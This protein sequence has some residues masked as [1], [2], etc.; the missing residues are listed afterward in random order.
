MDFDLIS[1]FRSIDYL[2]A[3]TPV[4]Q[5]LLLGKWFANTKFHP[6]IIYGSAGMEYPVV[7]DKPFVSQ[8][9]IK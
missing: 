6:R 3:G 5:N 7:I 1:I 8:L 2:G 4:T 9:Q